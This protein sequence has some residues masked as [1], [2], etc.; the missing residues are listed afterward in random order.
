MLPKAIGQGCPV[1]PTPC[2]PVKQEMKHANF[3]ARCSQPPN[4]LHL[5]PSHRTINSV[6]IINKTM[7]K[8][9]MLDE[10]QEASICGSGGKG[11]QDK[12]RRE[13]PE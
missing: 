5:K 7:Q 3:L 6:N 13:Y 1:R 2:W 9:R 12:S 11:Y 8:V 4:L 10:L